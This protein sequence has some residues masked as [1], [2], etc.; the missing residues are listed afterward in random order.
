MWANAWE[1]GVLML[2]CCALVESAGD[3]VGWLL[4]WGLRLKDG[5]PGPMGWQALHAV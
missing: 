3:A 4:L 1:P 5:H 2:W